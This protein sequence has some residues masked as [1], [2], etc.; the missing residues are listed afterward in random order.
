VNGPGSKRAW[1]RRFQ[2]ANRPGSESSKERIGQDSIW[3]IRSG[4]QMGPGAKRLSI[5]LGTIK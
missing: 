3:P 5:R 2:G 1:E 4:E